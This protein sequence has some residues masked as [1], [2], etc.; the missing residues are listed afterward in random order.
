MTSTITIC[1]TKNYKLINSAISQ[2]Y[3]SEYWILKLI[4]PWLTVNSQDGQSPERYSINNSFS[5]NY[6]I[7]HI[8]LLFNEINYS[9]DIDSIFVRKDDSNYPHGKL[10]DNSVIDMKVI[11][12]M[13]CHN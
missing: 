13:L 8:T 9:R 10:P 11:Y 6:E 12:Y 7:S 1:V 4:L 5:K 3:V 2:T